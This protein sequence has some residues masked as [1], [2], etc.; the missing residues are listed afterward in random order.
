[1]IVSKRKREMNRLHWENTKL[2]AENKKLKQM[3]TL[4]DSTIEKQFNEI[5]DLRNQLDQ[6]AQ[7]KPCEGCVYHH[8]L[9]QKCASCTRNPHAVDKFTKQ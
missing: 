7:R 3:L 8:R 2:D 4:N 1:V 9:P 6:A 5:G